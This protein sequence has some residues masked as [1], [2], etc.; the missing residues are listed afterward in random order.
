MRS[1][2]DFGPAPLPQTAWDARAAANFIA[3]GA[4]GG[5]IIVT[6]L[7]GSTG[8][9]RAALVLCGLALMGGG[10][11]AVW[12]ELGRPQRALNVFFH[13]RTSWMSREAIVATLLVP[14]ALGAAAG[15]AACGS[16]S[17]VLAAAFVACQ[18]RML[19]AARGIPAWREPLA[20]PLLV[21]TALAEGAGLFVA[22]STL[23]P[24]GTPESTL[25]LGSLALL[26]IVAWLAYRRAVARSAPAPALRA[27][28]HAGRVLQWV[29]TFA[30]LALIVIATSG[31]LASDASAALLACA[32]ISVVAAGAFVKYVLVLRAG[33][34][35][36]F[37]LAHRPVRG[38]RAAS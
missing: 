12:H 22:A 9:A 16:A 13:A 19:Q 37:A 29:G 15:I 17:A 27:L 21:V 14:T 6:A 33:F 4:G 26:R 18:A 38:A 11:L 35:Q 20:V 2:A 1:T 36:G 28:D 34:T 31:A 10:L 23:V 24:I 8:A 5:L 25:V 30:P 32:G 3:G 7:A